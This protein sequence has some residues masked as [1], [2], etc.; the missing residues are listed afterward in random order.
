M[1][2]T[3]RKITSKSICLLT[4]INSKNVR[5]EP[6]SFMKKMKWQFSVSFSAFTKCWHQVPFKSVSYLSMRCYVPC[7]VAQSCPTLCDSM[8]CSPP[9]SS[10][11]ILQARTL[12]R[13]AM[14]SSRG[15][16]RPRDWTQVSRIAGGC[17]TVWASREAHEVFL[18]FCKLRVFKKQ[19]WDC[20]INTDLWARV[21]ISGVEKQA[22]VFKAKQTSHC[23]KSQLPS[24]DSDT[25]RERL[26][27]DFYFCSHFDSQ[28]TVRDPRMI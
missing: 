23:K 6:Y 15:S 12:E 2:S 24:R 9:G 4:W 10:A 18:I 16:F 3:K 14:P 7:L 20:L 21:S 19:S 11:G 5:G 26:F 22:S 13:V 25:F 28:W 1:V 27:L 8:D 17:F